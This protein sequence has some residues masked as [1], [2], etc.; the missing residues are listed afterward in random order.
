MTFNNLLS[1]IAS[2][3]K[4]ILMGSTLDSFCIASGGKCYIEPDFEKDNDTF[5]VEKPSVVLIFFR[6]GLR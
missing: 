3:K 5:K 2:Q 6:R 1:L 4:P